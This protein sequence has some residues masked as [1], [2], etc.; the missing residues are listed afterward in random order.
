MPAAGHHLRVG[1]GHVALHRAQAPLQEAARAVAA[2]G[3]RPRALHPLLPLRA[4]LAGD[5]RGLPADPA[6]ARGALVRR[7]VRRASLRRPVLRQ[8]HRAVPSGRADL[9]RVPLPRAAVGHRG[10]RHRL[11]RLRRPLQRRADGPRRA[12]DARARPRSPRGGRRL[13]VRPRA[14]RLPARARG[15]T[16]RRAARARGH[17]AHAR[18]VGEGARRRERGAEEGGRAYGRA[19]RRRDHQR[20]GVP[21]AAPVPRGPRLR[22]PRLAPARR[23]AARRGAC[24]GEPR[25]AGVDP[26]PRVRACRP[27]RR[28]RPDRRVADARPADPQ[29]RAPQPR[30]A[31]RRQRTADRARRRRRR[32]RPLRARHGGRRTGRRRRPRGVAARRGRGRRDRLRRAGAAPATGPARCSTSPPGSA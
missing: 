29:G 16:G 22:P 10:R 8:H 11:H 25:A 20:G 32:R 2:G 31:R 5:L 3:D 9:A 24:A 23:A 14:L 4:L 7:D 26:R 1:P 13:A 15:R 6:G 28:L 18:L 21:A 17:G 12:G 19:G 27:A 30:Q